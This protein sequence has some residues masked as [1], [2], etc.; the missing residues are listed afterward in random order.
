MHGFLIIP[1]FIWSQR[2]E[3]NRRHTDYESVAPNYSQFS[4]QITTKE[5]DY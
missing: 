4:K 3:L 2:S 5:S 1:Y